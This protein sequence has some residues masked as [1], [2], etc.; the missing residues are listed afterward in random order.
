MNQALAA[1][2][3]P[4]GQH[5]RIGRSSYPLITLPLTYPYSMLVW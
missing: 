3:L 2:R 1:A 4:C 5:F